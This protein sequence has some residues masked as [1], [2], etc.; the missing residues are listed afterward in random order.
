MFWL[1]ITTLKIIPP[2]KSYQKNPKSSSLSKGSI[3]FVHESVVRAVL[4][5][6]SE[7]LLRSGSMGSA[8]CLELE[9]LGLLTCTTGLGDSNSWWQQK[10]RLLGHLILPL[11]LCGLSSKRASGQPAFLDVDPGLQRSMFQ[12]RERE[13]ARNKLSFL[14]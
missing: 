13:R 9:S 2:K 11:P 10:L 14:F 6:V 5:R 12:K 3:Y 7:H 1:S 8:Q 4:S